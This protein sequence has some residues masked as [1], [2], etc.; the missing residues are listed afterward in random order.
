ML[1]ESRRKMELLALEI[2]GA[3]LHGPNGQLASALHNPTSE[4]AFY[5][6]V[7]LAREVQPELAL[8]YSR[9]Q[10]KTGVQYHV[11]RYVTIRMSGEFIP[12]TK[13]AVSSWLRSNGG[14]RHEMQVRSAIELLRNQVGALQSQSSKTRALRHLRLINQELGSD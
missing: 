6:A 5:D 3:I 7:G 12:A 9:I 8:H 11:L 2:E 14:V 1:R 10:N 13:D 4:V